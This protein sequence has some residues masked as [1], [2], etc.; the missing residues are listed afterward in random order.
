[1]TQQLP[2]QTFEPVPPMPPQ[3]PKRK[4]PWLAIILTTVALF[5]GAGAGYASGSS[6]IPDTVEVEKEVE[7][8]VDVPVTPSVC[9]EAL[10]LAEDV[11]SSAARSLG[12]SNDSLNAVG[13]LD[14]KRIEANGSKI[15]AETAVLEELGVKYRDARD[16]CLSD[17]N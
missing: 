11:I 4:M 1:M 2:T 16:S 5:I 9:T 8:R 10:S 12:Y 14:A 6:K 13:E 7:K 17:A 3:K 15:E